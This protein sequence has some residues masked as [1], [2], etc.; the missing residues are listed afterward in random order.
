MALAK[1][2]PSDIGSVEFDELRKL[3]HTLLHLLQ[4]LNSTDVTDAT[5]LLAAAQAIGDAVASGVTSS[6]LGSREVVGV[7]PKV[8]RP[9]APQMSSN[10]VT[11]STASKNY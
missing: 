10:K 7:I 3:V 2:V 8:Q 1:V 4:T 5:E 9:P 11:L 6:A